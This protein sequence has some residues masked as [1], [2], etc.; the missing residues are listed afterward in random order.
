ML[1]AYVVHHVKRILV[2]VAGS[3]EPEKRIAASEI[4]RNQAWLETGVRP[5][6]RIYLGAG[7]REP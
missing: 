4:E 6:G 2:D 5:V 3:V 1:E 7:P